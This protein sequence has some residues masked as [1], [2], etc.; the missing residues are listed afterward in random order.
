MSELMRK[1]LLSTEF[2]AET[3]GVLI[4]IFKEW[5]RD[6]PCRPRQKQLGDHAWSTVESWMRICSCW[7]VGKALTIRSM[8]L[9]APVRVEVFQKPG[10]RFRR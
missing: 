1:V 5:Q 8:V 10:G 4:M 3:D 2:K 7:L 9:A 6:R